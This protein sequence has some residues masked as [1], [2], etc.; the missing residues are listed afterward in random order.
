MGQRRKFTVEEDLQL[1]TLVEQLGAK[2]WDSVAQFMPG[3]TARQCRDRYKNYLLDSLVNT[4]WTPEEDAVVL[5]R[6][7]E[8]GP[9]WVEIAKTLNGRSGNHVKNRWY[10]HLARQDCDRSQVVSDDA[11][12]E[13]DD[14]VK[15][16]VKD[17][18]KDEIKDIVKVEVPLLLLCP[19]F[20]L[21]QCDWSEL[22]DGMEVKF[23]YNSAWR[24]SK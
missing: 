18:I 23:G 5:E 16:K 7:R 8:L 14:E 6:Y 21:R 19:V 24:N 3:R 17:E 1:R 15:D 12:M 11:S 2:C 4:L 22:F 10:R 20:Q 9:R 13:S